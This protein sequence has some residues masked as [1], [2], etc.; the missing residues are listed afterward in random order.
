MASFPC[1]CGKGVRDRHLSLLSKKP[2]HLALPV[3]RPPLT[4]SPPPGGNPPL[5]PDPQR[6]LHGARPTCLSLPSIHGHPCPASSF[7]DRRSFPLWT[8]VAPPLREGATMPAP[9]SLSTEAEP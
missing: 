8:E 3:P 7:P 2:F 1:P 6:G 5:T 4:P 9:K